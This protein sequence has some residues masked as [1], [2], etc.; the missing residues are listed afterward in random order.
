MK[1]Q[2]N[3]L[4]KTYSGIFGNQVVLQTLFLKLHFCAGFTN[5]S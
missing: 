3:D 4:L 2:T 5:I 1:T